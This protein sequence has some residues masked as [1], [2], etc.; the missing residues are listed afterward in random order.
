MGRAVAHR[1]AQEGAS[2]AVFDVREGAADLVASEIRSNQHIAIG[3]TGDVSDS[4]AVQKAIDA[5]AGEFGGLDT[6]VTCAGITIYGSTESMPLDVWDKTISVNLTGTFLC[7]KY[8]LPH[9]LKAGRGAIVT[10][11]SIAALVAASGSCAY[12][13]SKG[14][15]LQLTRSVAAEH[16]ENNIRA[17]C[18]CP[19]SVATD[20]HKNTFDVSGLVTEGDRVPVRR[21]QAPMPRRADPSEIA[22]VVAFLCSDDASFVTGIAIPVDGGMTAV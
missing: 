14:G 8:A 9:L 2:V 1:L 5:A 13:A 11:S 6:V 17:N 15:I 10:V 22:S 7:I 3:L 21:T 18:L 16:A 19:G 12:D 4:E 20:L